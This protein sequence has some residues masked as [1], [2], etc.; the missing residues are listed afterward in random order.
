MIMG[1]TSIEEC[2]RRDFVAVRLISPKIT[3][4]HQEHFIFKD[5]LL[6]EDIQEPLQEDSAIQGESQSFRNNND[7]EETEDSVS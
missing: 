7:E 1:P 4:T 2:G 5:M 6:L 3:K